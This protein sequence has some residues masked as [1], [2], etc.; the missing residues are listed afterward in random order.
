MGRGR[1][2]ESRAPG[3]AEGHWGRYQQASGRRLVACCESRS[4]R[5]ITASASGHSLLSV[6][7]AP[8]LRGAADPVCPPFLSPCS[9]PVCLL[10]AAVFAPHSQSSRGVWA[11]WARG[12]GPVFF[13]GQFSR[14]AGEWMRPTYTWTSCPRRS[15]GFASTG[16]PAAPHAQRPTRHA[17]LVGCSAYGC[18]GSSRLRARSGCEM[19]RAVDRVTRVCLFWSSA[20]STTPLLAGACRRAC[21]AAGGFED[22]AMTSQLRRSRVA[23]RRA[24]EF[25]AS[26]AEAAPV[27]T[28]GAAL[29]R[30]SAGARAALVRHAGCAGWPHLEVVC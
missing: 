12:P 15:A 4:T 10:F 16:E 8:V 22:L 9:Y 5:G 13:C 7:R 19:G 20:C 1:A 6:T 18:S 29:R 27:Q 2:R 23:G 28:A 3:A 26:A 21:E 30:P 11:S 25:F 14:N 24:T 17:L